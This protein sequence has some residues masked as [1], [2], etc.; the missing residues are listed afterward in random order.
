MARQSRVHIDYELWLHGGGPEGRGEASNTG[1]GQRTFPSPATTISAAL[2][3]CPTSAHPL[4]GTVN[5]CPGNT[6]AARAGLL[7]L[8]PNLNTQDEPEFKTVIAKWWG[9]RLDPDGSG[10]HTNDAV[11]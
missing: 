2:A 5:N 10:L 1:K 8:A 4:L 9:Q 3:T 6:T 11:A 7:G